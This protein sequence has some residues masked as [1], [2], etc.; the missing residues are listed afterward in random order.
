MLFT[1]VPQEESNL[2]I[3]DVSK[4]T[5]GASFP[6]KHQRSLI[7]TYLFMVFMHRKFQNFMH[8]ESF[9]SCKTPVFTNNYIEYDI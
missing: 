2:N 6:V 9:I 1:H 8:R 4:P 7:I 5:E 3:F